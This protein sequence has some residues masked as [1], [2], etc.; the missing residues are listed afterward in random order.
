MTWWEK[1]KESLRSFMMGRNGADQLAF[2]SLIAGVILA[3]LSG[4][5]G[6]GV[7]HVLSTVGYLYALFRMLSR[8]IAKRQVENQRFMEFFGGTKDKTTQGWQRLKNSATYKYVSCPECKTLLRLPRK[9]KD[10][11]KLGSVNVTCTKC[12]HSFTTKV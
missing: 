2:A 7:L 8:N 10:G 5:T 12:R 6:S 1:V 4:F 11:K 9:G 3:L